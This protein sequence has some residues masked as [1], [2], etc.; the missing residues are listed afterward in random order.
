MQFEVPPRITTLAPGRNQAGFYHAII[1]EV[2]RPSKKRDYV[3]MFQI[4]PDFHFPL[5]SLRERQKNFVPKYHRLT[6]PHKLVDVVIIGVTINS[7]QYFDTDNVLVKRSDMSA[8]QD[9]MK[10]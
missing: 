5:Q 8:L 3:R 7:I 4:R 1:V 9:N 2:E 6:Y 10:R